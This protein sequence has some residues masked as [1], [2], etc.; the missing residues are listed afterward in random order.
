MNNNSTQPPDE[1]LSLTALSKILIHIVQKLHEPIPLF[2]LAIA[3]I[4]LMAA[5][6]GGVNL[7]VELRILFAFLSVLGFLGILIPQ[8]L[9]R[10]TYTNIKSTDSGG[11]RVTSDRYS[12]DEYRVLRRFLDNLNDTQFQNMRK[13]LLNPK[14]QD[15][16]IKSITKSS[17]LSDM[18]RWNRLHEVRSYLQENFPASF[19]ME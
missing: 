18:Q 1:S 10:I 17:F 13:D 14:E 2:L 8:L 12:Q 16:L 19:E 4:I 11:V 3:I 15:D 5:A 7:I 6:V 9:N